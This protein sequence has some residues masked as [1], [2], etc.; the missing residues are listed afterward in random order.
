METR[1]DG[2]KIAILSTDGFEQDELMKPRQ[3][4]LDAGAEVKIVSLKSGMIKGWLNADWGQSVEVDMTLDESDCGVFDAL[5]LP[6]GVINPDKL[7]NDKDAIEFVQGF[8]TA[9]KP[10]AAICH[11]PQTLIETGM[12]RGRK[13]TS[14][15]SL[16]TDL[17]NAGALWVD[18][19][20]VC[21]HGLVTSRMP[22]DIPAFNKKMIEEFAEGVHDGPRMSMHSQMDKST[23]TNFSI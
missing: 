15:P 9:G 4:L 2:K 11:G 6:G 18:Q 1:L 7:R 14:W 12:V 8:V 10:I 22:S 21:D 20:V 3:A 16:K 13:M 5:M 17:L 19:E 23:G